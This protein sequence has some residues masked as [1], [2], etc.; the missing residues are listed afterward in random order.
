M[1]VAELRKKLSD[2]PK[3]DVS[4]LAVEFYKMIPKSKKKDYALDDLI[5]N[6]K[7]RKKRKKK[8]DIDLEQLE[9]DID[10]FIEHARAQYYVAPNQVIPKRERPKWRFEVMRW[11]KTLINVKK[12][13]ADIDLQIRLLVKLYEL[14]CEASSFYLF[15]TDDPFRSVQITQTDFFKSILMLYDT[16]GN[17]VKLADKGF[18]L[19]SE[20]NLDRYSLHSGIADAYIGFLPTPDLKNRVIDLCE[21]KIRE[22]D[23]KPPKKERSTWSFNED[24]KTRNQNNNLAILGFR[25]YCSLYEADEAIHFFK[26]HYYGNSAEIKTYVLIYQLLH[27]NLKDEI[28]RELKDARKNGVELRDRLKNLQSI[29]ENSGKLPD[30]I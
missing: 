10:I 16:S 9:S 26:K 2:M 24:Y 7:K 14:L 1:K 20:N 17:K 27:H 23:Y 8:E 18:E 6:P 12:P 28:I 25:I 15:S 22:I 11:Y 29:I 5:N 13:D 3:E 4:R 19:L 30:Y 21:A